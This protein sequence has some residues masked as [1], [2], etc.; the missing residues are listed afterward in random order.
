MNYSFLDDTIAHLYA[1]EQSMSRLLMWATRLMIFIS[2]LGLLGLVIYTTNRRTKEM[3]VRKILGA[4]IA[5]IVSILSKD[6]LLLLLT[7]FLT[8]A[9]IAGWSVHKWLEN[10]VN[11]TS[12]SWWIFALTVIMIMLFAIVTLSIQKIKAAVANPVKNLRTE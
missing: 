3:G 2:C 7:A 8:A 9:P 11:R 4:S 6:Y 12:I 5:N 1:S 10:F